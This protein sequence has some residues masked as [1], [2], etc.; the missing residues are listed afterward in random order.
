MLESERRT[1]KWWVLPLSHQKYEIPLKRWP[2]EEEAARDVSLLNYTYFM[3]H[4]RQ[5]HLPVNIARADAHT[6]FAL[7]TL[8][9]GN[10]W[11]KR[12]ATV[13]TSLWKTWSPR[14]RQPSELSGTCLCCSSVLCFDFECL[15]F[16]KPHYHGAVCWFIDAV[17][18]L[19]T[20]DVVILDILEIR[21]ETPFKVAFENLQKEKR[22]L[23]TLMMPFLQDIPQMYL[24]WNNIVYSR[25]LKDAINIV[26]CS[27][28]WI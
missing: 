27:I 26:S 19:L 10:P 6:A 23:V 25:S 11:Q 22:F 21:R 14:S 2:E 13:V 24:L 5:S 7:Q 3:W 28:Q 1:L 16:R 12:E 20:V 9:Q 8:E 18:A 4:F 15:C 17:I